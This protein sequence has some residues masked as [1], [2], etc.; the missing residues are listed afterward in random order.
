M[1]NYTTARS[2]WY[3]R[4]DL[5]AKPS[6]LVAVRNLLVLT[7]GRLIQTPNGYW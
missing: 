1:S 4:L 7:C 2:D 5:V 6:L 3:A